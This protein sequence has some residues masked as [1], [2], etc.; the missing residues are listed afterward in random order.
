MY[1]YAKGEVTIETYDR[2]TGKRIE[3]CGPSDNIVTDKG[4]GQMWRRISMS[5][6]SGIFKFETIAIGTDFGDPATWSVFNPEPATRDFTSAD[7]T[8]IYFAKVDQVFYD[9]PLDPTIK[10]TAIIDGAMTM[11]QSFSDQFSADFSS[12]TLRF[13]NGETFAYKRFPIRSIT[14]DVNIKI[15]WTI[16]LKNA[17]EYCNEGIFDDGITLA[18][19][20]TDGRNE[21]NELDITGSLAFSSRLHDNEVICVASDLTK[22][23]YSASAIDHVIIKMNRSG[24]EQWRYDAHT[25]TITGL[26]TDDRGNL[27]TSSNDGTIVKLNSDGLPLW[28]YDAG[29]PVVV[30]DV[31]SNGSIL[32]YTPSNNVMTKL[33]S[34]GGLVWTSNYHPSTILDVAFAANDSVY[35][36]SSDN[37]LRK[38]DFD[39]SFEWEYNGFTDFVT[40]VSGDSLNNVVAGSND[41]TVRKVSPAKT[42]VWKNTDSTEWIQKVIVDAS[43][44]I[45]VLS[46]DGYIR[47]LN[48]DGN[49]IWMYAQ[50]EDNVN[51]MAVNR[52]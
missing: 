29:M 50:E 7:Q 6:S 34:N 33:N 15:V 45:F 5:D 40:S 47:K 48:S 11:A 35:T 30:G 13:G 20:C 22:N 46:T 25:D 4:I 43:N 49:Q 14:R 8:A 42:E 23:I 1:E 32:I 52:N 37:L 31:A 36:G 10:V 18:Y 9:Y 12:A 26:K 24:V 44:S 28:T 17:A 27:Y 38:F 2:K 51:D 16:T 21:V 19:Y 3:I 41:K 39:G